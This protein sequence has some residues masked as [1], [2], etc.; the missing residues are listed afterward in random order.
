MTEPLRLLVVEDNPS[1][2][3]LLVRH[4]N[5][6]GIAADFSRIE[7]LVELNASL[8]S[9]TWDAAL[10]DHNLPSIHF[11]DIMSC[12]HEHNIELPIIMVSGSVPEPNALDLLQH[13]LWDY[14]S[15]D[16]LLKL[17]NTLT[18][19]IDLGTCTK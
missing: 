14:V 1:D 8:T 11:A 10:V 15:K 16:N 6:S 5:Q 17:P 3:K 12:I 19:A 2:F 4:L 13:G 18:H 9:T 7:S